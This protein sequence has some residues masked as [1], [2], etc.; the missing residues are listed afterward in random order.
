MKKYFCLVPII[1]LFVLS[2]LQSDPNISLVKKEFKTYVQRTFDDPGALKEIVEISPKD[3]ISY[4]S[5]KDI[6]RMTLD[7]DSL[8]REL[9]S[10]KDSLIKKRMA[11]ATTSIKKKAYRMDFSDAFKGQMIVSDALS[12]TNSTIEALK[13]KAVLIMDLEEQLD[14]LVYHTPLYLYKLSY[15]VKTPEG[16]K[17]NEVFAYVDSLTGV[18]SIRESQSDREEMEEDYSK[19]ITKSI[20][21][22]ELIDEINS[23]DEKNDEKLKELESF[24]NSL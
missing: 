13:E 5:I 20:K 3:T 10:I 6:I 4:N 23:L 14:S 16:L 17:L 2:C 15:R 8:N 11:D 9:R 18:K 19:I 24:I 12:I 1:C 21:T 22:M 7:T